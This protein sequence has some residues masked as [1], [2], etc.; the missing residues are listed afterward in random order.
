MIIFWNRAEVYTGFSIKRFSEVRD[1]LSS[2]EIK[3]TYKVVNR[4]TSSG[5][6][7]K[8]SYIGTLGENLQVSYEYYVYVNKSDS[9]NAYSLI[10]KS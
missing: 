7:S 9:E 10:N 4:N 3:Y 1:I 2:N 8:R 6:D 5:F